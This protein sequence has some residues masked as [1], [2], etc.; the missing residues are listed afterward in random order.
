MRQDEA[1]GSEKYWHSWLTDEPETAG[2]VMRVSLV[3]LLVSV[4]LWA[5]GCCGL[6]QLLNWSGVMW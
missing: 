6:Y 2:E 3:L 1:T 4:A 5:V